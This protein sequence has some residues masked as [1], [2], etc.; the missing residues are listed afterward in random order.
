MLAK[1]TG[2]AKSIYQGEHIYDMYDIINYGT[3]ICMILLIMYYDMYDIMNYG[4]I[5]EMYDIINYG[6]IYDIIN[7]GIYYDH[8]YGF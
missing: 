1:N 6:T 5:Y 4:T 3:M 2:L 7:Y 8:L